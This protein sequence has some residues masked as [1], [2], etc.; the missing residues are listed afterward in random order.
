MN[1]QRFAA[2]AI[3][4]TLCAAALSCATFTSVAFAEA[5][6]STIYRCAEASGAMA[7]QDFPCK[8]GVVVD[9]RPGVANQAEIARL[10]RA[11]EA[12]ERAAALRKA[13]EL[14]ALRREELLLRRQELEYS[15]MRDGSDVAGDDLLY[16]P[17]YGFGGYWDG[18]R[19]GDF[20]R[21]G[22]HQMRHDARQRHDFA[23]TRRIPAVIHRPMSR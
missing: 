18:R 10:A 3:R 13:D 4:A 23:S 19:T 21:S 1:R 2:V 20:R 22:D 12:F 17:A 8:G 11:E 15:R 5:S 16:A 7:Y 9:I 6:P 14:A